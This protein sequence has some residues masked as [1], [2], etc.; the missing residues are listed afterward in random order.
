MVLT[1]A[2]RRYDWCALIMTFH[3]HSVMMVVMNVKTILVSATIASIENIR[4]MY[5][6]FLIGTDEA[7]FLYTARRFDDFRVH[8]NTHISSPLRCHGDGNMCH[9]KTIERRFL[10]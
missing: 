5:E 7:R 2:S 1:V 8:I 9:N 4:E 10:Q 3:F 6:K